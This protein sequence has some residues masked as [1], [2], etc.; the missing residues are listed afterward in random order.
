MFGELRYQSVWLNL[1][2]AATAAE[3]R[4]MRHAVLFAGR[5]LLALGF[6]SSSLLDAQE[7]NASSVGPTIPFELRSDFLVVVTGQVGDLHGLKFIL[8]T[9]A[10]YTLIDQKIADRLK[11]RRRPGKITNFNRDVPVELAEIPNLRVGPLQTG[12]HPVLV[13]KLSDYSEFA[14]NVD[15]IIGLDLLGRSKKLFIDYEKLTVSWELFESGV[16]ALPTATYFTVP[17]VVQGF[18]M[19]LVVDTGFQGILLYKDRLRKGLPDART[20]GKAIEGGMGRLQTTQ[21]KLPGVRLFGPETVATVFLTD[22]PASGQLPGID[23]YLGVASLQA[24]RVEFDFA[25]RILR[26]R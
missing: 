4:R 2:L 12:A 16:A 14:E 11:L 10:S 5:I 7:L 8:D 1:G 22:G 9:G 26:W 18:P 15:G 3:A 17:F 6:I 23:G 25:A 21:V 19:H 20:E 13:A 24:K